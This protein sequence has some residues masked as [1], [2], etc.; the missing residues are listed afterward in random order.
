MTL[1]QAQHNL[2][3][4]RD[5]LQFSQFDLAR[6]RTF[7]ATVHIEIATWHLYRWLDA[8]WEAQR[9]VNSWEDMT[10]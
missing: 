3:V 10:L 4:V 9:E 6:A 7:H 8:A 2:R 1:E 5:Q